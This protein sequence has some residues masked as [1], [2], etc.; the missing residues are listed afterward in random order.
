ML[1]IV[2]LAQQY[3]IA[4]N[5]ARKVLAYLRDAGLVEIT[6]GWGS[7]VQGKPKGKP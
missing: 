3:G 1:S 5:T 2:T 4:R 7:F 6:P